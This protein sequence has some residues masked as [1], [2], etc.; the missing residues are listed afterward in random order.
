[1]PLQQETRAPAPFLL[2]LLL[3][4]SCAPSICLMLFLLSSL[5]LSFCACPLLAKVD[6]LMTPRC[7]KKKRSDKTKR[8]VFVRYKKRLGE[9][10]ECWRGAGKLGH[11]KKKKNGQYQ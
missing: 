6:M 4:F 8:E 7:V 9:A 10:S 11:E 5:H 2:L 1:M 3:S